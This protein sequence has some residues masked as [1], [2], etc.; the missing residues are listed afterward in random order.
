[1]AVAATLALAE[2]VAS[3]SNKQSRAKREKRFSHLCG[4]GGLWLEIRMKMLVAL[5]GT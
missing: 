1:M 4:L 3:K 5:S 2:G